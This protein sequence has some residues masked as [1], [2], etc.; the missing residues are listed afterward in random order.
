MF[1]FV[2]DESLDTVRKEGSSSIKESG[3]SKEEAKPN[4]SQGQVVF[5]EGAMPK[6]ESPSAGSVKNVE[7]QQGDFTAVAK[8]VLR[9][10]ASETAV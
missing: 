4:E 7:I 3:Q 8:A 1:L 10:N 6:V 5:A 2:Q 9:Q